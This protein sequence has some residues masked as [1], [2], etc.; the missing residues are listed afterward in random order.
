MPCSGALPPACTRPGNRSNCPHIG[1]GIRI[2]SVIGRTPGKAAGRRYRAGINHIGDSHGVR[3]P[4]AGGQVVQAVLFAGVGFA[5]NGFRERIGAAI[6]RAGRIIRDPGDIHVDEPIHRDRRRI[7]GS[8]GEGRGWTEGAQ[9]PAQEQQPLFP[10][11][12]SRSEDREPPKWSAICRQDS[13][14]LIG[15]RICLACSHRPPSTSGKWVLI[16]A[17]PGIFAPGIDLLPQL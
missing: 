16:T 7:H 4:G 17:S 10:V 12:N 1:R 9:Q 6:V 2:D 14:I 15:R 5:I 8:A 13:G 11:R 3:V